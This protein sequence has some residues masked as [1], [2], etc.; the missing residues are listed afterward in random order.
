MLFSSHI[1]S[2]LWSLGVGVKNNIDN[3]D[4]LGPDGSQCECNSLKL[5]SGWPPKEIETGIKWAITPSCLY[6]F[7]AKKI[8]VDTKWAITGLKYLSQNWNLYSRYQKEKD[9]QLEKV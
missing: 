8:E 9:E 2:H 1:S 4:E 7:M 6:Y 5:G 3:L